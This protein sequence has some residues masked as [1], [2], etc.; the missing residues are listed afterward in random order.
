[1]RVVPPG[2]PRIHYQGRWDLSD[3]LHA[4][5]SWPGVALTVAFTGRLIGVRLDDP[6][7]YWNVTVDGTDRGVFHGSRAG[8]RDYI[9]ADDL[10]D[11]THLLRFSRRNITFEPPYTLSGLLIDSTANLA[12]APLRSARRI[13]FIGDSFTA[14][15]SNEANVQQLAWEDRYPVTNIDLGFAA[16]I[17][18]HYGAE[19]ITT[20]RSGSGMICDW[21]GDTSARI[22]A[23]Y[24]RALMES[25]EPKW[26]F[27]DWIPQVATQRF[28]GSQ[29]SA[30]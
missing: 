16:V 19:Y 3:S 13:E 9:L 10:G 30:R 1:M 27:D 18:R 24:D 14:A 7:N 2:D 4:R 25:P 28:L 29:G 11:G 20:C 22:P 6:T 15:E 17:A 12:A 8:T 21:R 23:V 26:R 5:Y